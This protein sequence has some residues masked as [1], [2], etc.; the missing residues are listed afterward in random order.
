MLEFLLRKRLCLSICVGITS[1]RSTDADTDADA[2][3]VMVAGA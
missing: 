2:D 1:W 3:T